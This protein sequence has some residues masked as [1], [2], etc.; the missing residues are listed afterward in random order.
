MARPGRPD[1]PSPSAAGGETSFVNVQYGNV[2]RQFQ[3]LQKHGEILSVTEFF[4]ILQYYS[5]FGVFAP[6][7]LL[8]K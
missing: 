4:L 2:E 5:L 3:S 7:H 6:V 1:V 8:E